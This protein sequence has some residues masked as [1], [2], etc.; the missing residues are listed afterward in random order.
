MSLTVRP[1]DPARPAF[2]GIATGVD[3]RQADPPMQAAIEAAMDTYAVLVFPGQPLTNEE[4]LAFSGLFGPLETA[5]SSMRPGHTHRFDTRL[6][7]ISNLNAEGQVAAADDRRWLRS[8]ANRLW[9]S[10]SSYKAT[11][12]KYSLLSARILPS[13]G[14]ETDFADLRAAYDALPDRTKARIEDMVALHSEAVSRAKVGFFDYAASE[15]ALNEPVP[16]AVVRI[17]PGSKRRT[18]FLASHAGEIVGLTVPEG[19]MLLLDLM[20]HA[21]QPEFTH[22]HHWQPGDL[23]IWDNRCVMHRA[24]EFDTREVRDMRRTTVADS[25]PTLEQKKRLQEAAA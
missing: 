4:Q 14:G 3:L 2:V 8:L 13:W 15:Q 12:S 23:V 19:R 10:D 17:H 11:P 21:T 20:E 16:Q 9:H 22:R 24:R 6:S 7:D 18:L 5:R 1:A 25:A